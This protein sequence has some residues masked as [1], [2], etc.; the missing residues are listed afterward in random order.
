MILQYKDGTTMEVLLAEMPAIKFA[1]GELCLTGTSTNIKCPLDD[2]ASYS[3]AGQIS[4]G[5]DA[6]ETTDISFVRE[7][8]TI[9]I[10]AER[11]DVEVELFDIQGYKLPAE[12]VRKDD[13][14]IVSLE[15]LYRGV[16]ILSVNGHAIKIIKQ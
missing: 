4:T 8:D 9:K 15:N 13:C 10:F 12:T 16:Y 2:V 3:F 5:V 1:D 7:G 11:G 6:P 14:C